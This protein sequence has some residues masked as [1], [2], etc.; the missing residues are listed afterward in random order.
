MPSRKRRRDVAAGGL[1][2]L[3]SE[4]LEA[5]WWLAWLLAALV[6]ALWLVVT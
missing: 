6:W 2:R 4:H 5:T 3:M 1:W